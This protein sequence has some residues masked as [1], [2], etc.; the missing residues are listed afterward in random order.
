MQDLEP[1]ADK[2]RAFGFAVREVDGHDIDE[3]RDAFTSLPFDANKPTAIIA[4]TIKGKGAPFAE[5]NLKWHH[6]NKVSDAEVDSPARGP[7]RGA[8]ARALL[9]D[10]HRTGPRRRPRRLHRLGSR[11]R[12]DGRL[13]GRSSP[14]ASSWKA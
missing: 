7:R 2:W 9:E 4:H 11:R 1:L 8:D 13:Q 10:D 6:K 5:N 14:T 3:L 12:R